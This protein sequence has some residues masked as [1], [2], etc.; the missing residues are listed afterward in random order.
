LSFAVRRQECVGDILV[1]VF[2]AEP[3]DHMA[4][5]VQRDCRSE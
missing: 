3:G 1:D 2:V 4:H 5:L